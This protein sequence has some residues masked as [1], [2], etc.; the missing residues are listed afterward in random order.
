MKFP[1]GIAAIIGVVQMFLTCGILT[2]ETISMLNGFAYAFLFI[3]YST[4]F[5]FT[6]TWIAVY[7][8]RKSCYCSIRG[9][10]Y[11]KKDYYICSLL[12]F[13]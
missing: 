5:F 2:C 11:G 10:L 8:S 13:F 7:G 6:I 12:F 3:G 4:S 9:F 1:R